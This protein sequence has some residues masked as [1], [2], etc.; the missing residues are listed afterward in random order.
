MS[1]R[2]FGNKLCVRYVFGLSFVGFGNKLC[3]GSGDVMWKS[4]PEKRVEVPE[5]RN[6]GDVWVRD[7]VFPSTALRWEGNVEVA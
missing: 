2:P 4:L 6:F 5:E 7:S 1:E 3:G